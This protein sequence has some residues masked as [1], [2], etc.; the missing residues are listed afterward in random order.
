[1]T[2]VLN[3]LAKK[4]TVAQMKEELGLDRTVQGHTRYTRAKV[5]ELWLTMMNSGK[6]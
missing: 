3:K 5:V 4:K 1:M 6:K 2:E